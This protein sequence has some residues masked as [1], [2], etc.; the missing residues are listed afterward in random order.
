[1]L[2]AF[3]PTNGHQQSSPLSRIGIGP[4]DELCVA[5]KRNGTSGSSRE[6]DLKP[7]CNV[8]KRPRL[9]EKME[10]IN[11]SHHRMR[12]KRSESD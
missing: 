10:N 11:D 5:D 4:D 3:N 1:L 12:R 9:A 6:K 2:C 8:F 7:I